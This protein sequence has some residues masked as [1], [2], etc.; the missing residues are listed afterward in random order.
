[1]LRAIGEDNGRL[2]DIRDGYTLLRGLYQQA[3]L[4]DNRPYWLQNNLAHYDAAAQLW[5]GRSDRWDLVLYQW[6]ETHTLPP[7]KEVGLPEPAGK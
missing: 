1:M 2:K 5:L 7:A 4:R 6:Y 3:W